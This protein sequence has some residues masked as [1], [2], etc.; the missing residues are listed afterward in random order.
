MTHPAALAF[1]SRITSASVAVLSIV[2]RF[3][4]VDGHK[5][6]M[7]KTAGGFGGTTAFD[8]LSISLSCFGANVV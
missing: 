1:L 7:R 3:V 2:M 8:I 6:M 5:K 4:L